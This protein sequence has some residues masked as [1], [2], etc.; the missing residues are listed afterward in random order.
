MVSSLSQSWWNSNSISNSISNANSN[1]NSSS[2]LS[3]NWWFSHFPKSD[4]LVPFPKLMVWSISQSWWFGLFR[5]VHALVY[6]PKLMAWS[7]SR[8]WWLGLVPKVD[9][10][11]TRARTRWNPNSS[12]IFFQNWW[13]SH[14]PKSDSLV[15]FP[16]LMVWSISQSWWFGIFL[17]VGGLFFPWVS[18]LVF[19]S[20]F[21]VRHQSQ[22]SSKPSSA[23][24]GRFSGQ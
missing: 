17:S 2:N 18:D 13:F 7:I 1:S 20:S 21:F 8:S 11:R 16:K 14:F 12:S 10:T 19:A 3:Q 24:V 15:P 5:K 22:S 4:G 23:S 6:F 9:A